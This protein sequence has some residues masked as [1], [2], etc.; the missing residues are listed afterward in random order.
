MYEQVRARKR[1]QEERDARDAAIASG[2]PIPP[3]RQT[4]PCRPEWIIKTGDASRRNGLHEF[5]SEQLLQVKSGASQRLALGSASS[6]FKALPR[7]EKM[8][9]GLRAKTANAVNR[10]LKLS[11]LAAM[12]DSSEQVP[13]P[14]GIAQ[15][16]KHA[17]HPDEVNS[18]LQENKGVLSR[19]TAWQKDRTPIVEPDSAFPKEVTYDKPLAPVLVEALDK[20]TG[21]AY[22]VRES[23]TKIL[24]D[25]VEL[26]CPIG[27]PAGVA[28]DS[29]IMISEAQTGKAAVFKVIASQQRPQFQA[30]LIFYTCP[31]TEASSSSIDSIS[32]PRWCWRD[33]DDWIAQRLPIQ[34]E[35]IGGKTSTHLDLATGCALFG[36]GPY[37]YRLAVT[38]APTRSDGDKLPIFEFG[39]KVDLAALKTKNTLEV[40]V[41]FLFGFRSI[42]ELAPIP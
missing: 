38:G 25:L 36:S 8:K 31:G 24:G 7:P 34:A 26:H 11:R 42:W 41:A 17:L 6:R 1:D 33:C 35:T 39:P 19:S 20:S 21:F 5:C 18:I 40:I 2:I 9:Y 23:I 16:S 4:R 28:D 22:S 14:W 15:G 37:S 32:D 10:N 3:Q 30:R 29:L 12:T 13:S 27:C